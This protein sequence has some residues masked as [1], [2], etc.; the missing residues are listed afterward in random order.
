M[1]TKRKSFGEKLK[2]AFCPYGRQI[3][4]CKGQK[5]SLG[6]STVYVKK[7]YPLRSPP[8][9]RQLTG[10]HSWLQENLLKCFQVSAKRGSDIYLNWKSAPVRPEQEK[11]RGRCCGRRTRWRGGTDHV[12]TATTRYWRQIPSFCKPQMNLRAT[13]LEIHTHGTPGAVAT[14]GKSGWRC[15]QIAQ[16]M[17]KPGRDAQD[18]ICTQTELVGSFTHPYWVNQRT[19]HVHNVSKS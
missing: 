2:S 5:S 12:L 11:N 19:P 9:R 10:F 16:R 13:D 1:C 6:V 14:T 18:R 17:L 4:T 3:K 8:N 15:S 7:D